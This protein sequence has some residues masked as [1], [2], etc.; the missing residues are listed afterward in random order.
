SPRP[1]RPIYCG[2]SLDDFL[3]RSRAKAATDCFCERHKLPLAG[4]HVAR[5]EQRIDWPGIYERACDLLV[6]LYRDAVSEEFERVSVCRPDRA[7][8]KRQIHADLARHMC[9][10][11]CGA[12]V[13][14][15]TDRDLGHGKPVAW[16]SD[17]MRPIERD[18]DARAHYR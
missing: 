18:A 13:G 1:L 3:N 6:S 7:A 15:K 4:I 16:S 14:K 17:A 11:M 10:C 9:E 2:Q 5:I 8:G 12:D